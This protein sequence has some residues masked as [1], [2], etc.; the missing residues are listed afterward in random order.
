MA[1]D[2]DVTN[3][4]TKS[5][6][7]KE[8]L[9][10]ATLLKNL[11][12]NAVIR[13]ERGVGKKTLAR[14]IM[15][16]AEVIS[17]KNYNEILS[18]LENTSKLI[19]YDI[20]ELAN[21]K[22]VMEEAQKRNVRIIATSSKTYKN[23][24]LD[25]YF[26]INFLLPSLKER[27]EDVE[28]LIKRYIEEAKEIFLIDKNIKLERF[29]PDLSQNGIS[30]KRQ[31]IISLLLKDIDEKEIMQIVYNFLYDRL[32][33]NNDYKDFLHLYEAPLID[34]GLERFKSQLQLSQ[35]LGLNRNTL[36]K[37]IHDNKKYLRSIDE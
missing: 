34:A 13:G 5:K 22:V 4:I 9:K 7:S 16:E 18:L 21:I 25:K 24:E 37:K 17:A 10:T 35:I 36:R 1:L 15:P 2:V 28:Y 11:N 3:F 19:I 14:Y 31:V 6:A 27:P 20:Q 12:V 33:G 30:L 23:E 8:A 29:K 32:G 26:S